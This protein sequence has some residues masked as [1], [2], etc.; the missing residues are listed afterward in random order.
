MLTHKSVMCMLDAAVAKVEVLGQSQCIVIVD[1]NCF[2]LASSRMTGSK[3]LSLENARTKT[4]IAASV[5][6]PSTKIPEY[7]RRAISAATGNAVIGLPVDLPITFDGQVV[8]A[9]G[10]GPFGRSGHCGSVG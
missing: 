6:G 2:D 3:V 10:I 8:G 9:I 4:R 7:V 5:G 1:A